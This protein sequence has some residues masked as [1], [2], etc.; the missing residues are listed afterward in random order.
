MLD[1]GMYHETLSAE[2]S[3]ILVKYSFEHQGFIPRTPVSSPFRET[4]GVEELRRQHSTVVRGACRVAFVRVQEEEHC[5]RE[6][7]WSETGRNRME[8]SCLLRDMP[9][10]G[11]LTEFLPLPFPLD[12]R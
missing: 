9:L 10:S 8:R 2:H 12:G 6:A 3:K 1:N 4:R 5:R 11:R 7:D